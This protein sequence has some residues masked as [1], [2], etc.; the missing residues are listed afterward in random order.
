VPR[1]RD[2]R[3]AIFRSASLALL[4]R[5]IPREFRGRGLTA[6]E[7]D[8]AQE[9]AETPF[10][11]DLCDLLTQTL[12]FGSGFPDWR[13]RP[14]EEMKEWRDWLVKTIHFDVIHNDFWLREWEARPNDPRESREIVAYHLAAA[15]AMI[16]IFIHRAIPNEPLEA[17]N[18]VFSIHQTDIIVYGRN[19]GDYLRREFHLF[20]RR[21]GD[22]SELRPIRFWT[23]MLDVD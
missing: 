7:L 8:N 4:G 22:L 12:P 23:R 14:R 6:A 3:R 13:F 20:H 17:G 10:P 18:P 16:P 1:F 2:H 15:P 11:P 9:Q 5:R 21:I 19:L